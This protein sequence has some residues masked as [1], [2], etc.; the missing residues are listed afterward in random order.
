[1]GRRVVLPFD[2]E[3]F[4]RTSVT[5]RPGDWG[6]VYD[7]VLDEVSATGDLVTLE[8]GTEGAEAYAA[9]NDAILRHA[10]ALARESSDGALA[11][12]VWEGAPR[13]DDD[14]TAAF[15]EAARQRGLPL[16]SGAPRWPGRRRQRPHP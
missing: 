5:D 3:R 4:R 14:L 16:A 8:A 13:G 10:A 15:G 1:M 2:R 7:R 11:A 12:L 6:V 9:A